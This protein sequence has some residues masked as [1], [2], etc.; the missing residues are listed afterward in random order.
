MR[1]TVYFQKRIQWR[2]QFWHSVIPVLTIIFMV[3]F[4]LSPPTATGLSLYEIT[5]K[6]KNYTVIENDQRK[7]DEQGAEAEAEKTFRILMG[8]G[9]GCMKYQKEKSIC[10]RTFAF[11][12]S[13]SYLHLASNQTLTEKF[14]TTSFLLMN[15]VTLGLTVLGFLLFSVAPFL[16]GFYDRAALTTIWA[17]VSSVFL[18]FIGNA[19]ATLYLKHRLKGCV[20]EMR[21][22]LDN[23]FVYVF[24]LMFMSLL[25]MIDACAIAGGIK[26]D[27]PP[28]NQDDLTA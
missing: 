12:P 1:T 28:I 9:G 19:S 14:P 11:K 10:Q 15:H 2:R 13:S 26:R 25:T 16:P 6:P 4:V 22:K 21:V 8:P 23:G 5:D 20:P 24:F 3:L 17:F 18:L 7:R 27:P